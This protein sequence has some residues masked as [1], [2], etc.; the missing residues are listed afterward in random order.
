MLEELR[1]KITV[2]TP[3]GKQLEIDPISQVAIDDDNVREQVK[4]LPSQYAFFTA[5]YLSAKKRRD[6]AELDLNRLKA[7]K[8]KEIRQKFKKVSVKGAD[9]ELT[10]KEVEEYLAEDESIYKKEKEMIELATQSTQCYHLVQAIDKKQAALS[11]LSYMQAQER[12][13]LDNLNRD[14]LLDSPTIDPNLF[15]KSNIKEKHNEPNGTG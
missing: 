14:S 6:L 5:V 10:I 11:S 8:S 9:K 15:E 2:T 1:Y 7:A 12:K 4:L 13:V 3:S